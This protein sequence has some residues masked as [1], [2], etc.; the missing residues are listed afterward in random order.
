MARVREGVGLGCSDNSL[1]SMRLN[2]CFWD[3][4]P[5]S[6]QGSFENKGPLDTQEY[7]GI[8]Y[9]VFVGAC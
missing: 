4:V 9:R 5:E 6:L 2:I 7:I 1:M 8:T 3:M